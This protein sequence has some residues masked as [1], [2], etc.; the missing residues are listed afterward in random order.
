[1]PV[2]TFE[3]RRRSCACGSVQLVAGPELHDGDELLHD[4]GAC[5][6]VSPATAAI[7][8][9]AEA[10]RRAGIDWQATP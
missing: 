7:V 9:A 2:A 6:I 3:D 1:M 10:E 8:R 5:L 4:A